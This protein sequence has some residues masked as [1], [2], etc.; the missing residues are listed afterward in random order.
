MD[1][2][3]LLSIYEKTSILGLR[4]SQL[5]YG[6]KSTLSSQ[7]VSKCNNVKEIAHME[8]KQKKIPIKMMRGNQE[9]YAWDFVIV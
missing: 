2:Y 5:E 8:F 3:P 1:T 7:E 9:F 6:A 4:M